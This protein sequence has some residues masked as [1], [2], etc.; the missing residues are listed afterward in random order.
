MAGDIFISTDLVDV[1]RRADLWREATKPLFD[2]M[3]Y[4][5][6]EV[7]STEGTLIARP[8]GSIGLAYSKFSRKIYVR[9]R[10]TVLQGGLDNY[11]VQIMTGGSLTGDF[12]G[13][14]VSIRPGDIVI[15]DLTQTFRNQATAGSRLSFYIPRQ[16][17]EKAMNGKNLHGL[18]LR[19]E[20]P[21]TKLVTGYLRG[22]YSV[23]GQLSPMLADATH[24][25]A[26]TLIAAALKEDAL[27]DLA[28]NSVLKLALRQR[29]LAFIDQN[30]NLPELSPEFIM[31]RFHVSRS[32]L[33]RTFA[34]DGGIAK[35]LRDKR[36]DAAFVELTRK[37]SAA[38]SITEISYRFGFSSSNQLLRAFRTRFGMTPS[39][40]REER[41][42][43]RK[44]NEER[45]LD[46][47]T[48]FADLSAQIV[49]E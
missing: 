22:L 44:S 43:L 16:P 40:A 45:H 18:I 25:A 26:V 1:D 39:Q 14:D 46:L 37:D 2:A 23:G 42:I 20:W 5:D 30:L 29:I 38:L 11:L 31:S 9:D 28:G 49:E 12:N 33:Y 13:L 32:H 10:R 27:D 47:M 17:L 19:R 41:V 21:V 3:P 48:Y 34:D 36:L 15:M 7:I 6:D 4:P 8:I 35:V 24:E